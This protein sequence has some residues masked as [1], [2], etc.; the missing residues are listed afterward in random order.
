MR[1]PGRIAVAV[2]FLALAA[3]HPCAS[4][5]RA[6]E[7]RNPKYVIFLI[8]DGMGNV[9]MHAAEAFRAACRADDKVP[10][11]PKAVHLAM[12]RMADARDGAWTMSFPRSGS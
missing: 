11:G 6:E 9:Q 2:A 5:A 7:V 10:G 1:H 12:R 8:G 3:A 4:R